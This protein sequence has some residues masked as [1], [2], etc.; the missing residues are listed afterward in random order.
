MYLKERVASPSG[1]AY[2]G[3][4][5]MLPPS[6]QPK[7]ALVATCDGCGAQVWIAKGVE[8]KLD[9]NNHRIFCPP[10]TKI[11]KMV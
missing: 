5:L 2:P 8:D 1:K 6:S 4:V 11:R 9:K 3:A 7:D 10:C